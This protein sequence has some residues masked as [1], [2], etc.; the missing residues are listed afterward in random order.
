[1]IKP[2]SGFKTDIDGYFFLEVIGEFV[3]FAV[4]D[5]IFELIDSGSIKGYGACPEHGCR[6]VFEGRRRRNVIVCHKDCLNGLRHFCRV[7]RDETQVYIG[8]DG[9]FGGKQ[10]RLSVFIAKRNREAAKSK[11]LDRYCNGIFK[12]VVNAVKTD[13]TQDISS[14]VCEFLNRYPIISRLCEGDFFFTGAL[15]GVYGTQECRG[16][17]VRLVAGYGYGYIGL[18]IGVGIVVEFGLVDG[19]SNASFGKFEFF[20]SDSV[21][22]CGRAELEI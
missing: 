8:G 1:M 7:I 17:A 6:I 19:R 16:N 4:K 14:G 20:V 5:K 18:H 9:R 15:G 13:G 21:K 12:V 3:I 11:A 2:D 10:G 22:V